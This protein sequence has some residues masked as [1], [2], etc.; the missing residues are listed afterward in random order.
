MNYNVA[1]A[2]TR[3]IAVFL[4]ILLV[5]AV[6]VFG[7]AP[8]N[9]SGVLN[10]GGIKLGLDLAGGSLIVY[11]ADTDMTG[12]DLQMNMDAV[13]TLM[14]S[15]LDNL[16]FT[17]AV[18]TV[19]NKQI[20]I[21]I[22]SVTDPEEAIKKIGATAILQFRNA[23]GEVIIDGK[24]IKAAYAQY[25]AVDNDNVKEYFVAIELTDEGQQ[26]FKE[27]TRAAIGSYISIYL[28]EDLQST[29]SVNKEIDGNPIITNSA[30]TVD[31]VKWLASVINAGQLPFALENVQQD[32]VGATLGEKSLESCLIA[33][34][35]GILLVMAFMII[36]YKVP[37]VVAS[38]SLFAYT[39]LF[40]MVMELIQANLT[41]P[42]IAGIILSIGMAVD[43]NV[44][45]YERI[46]E[47]LRN[48]K[49]VKGAIEAGFNRAFTAIFDSNITTLI[50]AGVLWYFGSGSIKGFGTTLFIGVL[51]SMLTA[52]TLTKSLLRTTVNM[53][54]TKLSYYGLNEEK[55]VKKSLFEKFDVVKQRKFTLIIVACVIIIGTASM[56]LRGFNLD[57]DFSGGTEFILGIQKDVE[58]ADIDNIKSIVIGI[59]EDENK[60]VS[61]QKSAN[62]DTTVI[63]TTKELNEDQR[64]AVRTTI[65]D[66]YNID[67]DND[68]S[69][70]S[71]GKSI[72][73]KLRQT[74]I[75]TAAL[76]VL[77]VLVYISFRFAF[78]SGIAAI[79]CLVH[80]LFIVI[81]AYSLLQ[82]PVSSTIIAA[83][84]TILGYSINATI[85]IFDRIREESKKS[86]SDSF[87]TNVNKGASASMTRSINTTITTFLT[88]G[89]VF[90]FG[91]ESVRNFALP[92]M[93]GLI[94]GLFSSVMIS[95]PM[96]NLLK[97][98][99]GNI[100]IRNLIPK[101]LKK[102]A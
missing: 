51:L 77:L 91:V 4:C 66:K 3:F 11:E 7:F 35:I 59:A 95:G 84:L 21:E 42:G 2:I 41:L 69:V 67:D 36:I 72:S 17:E 81:A 27:G 57:I 49:S 20:S 12:D 62:D 8:L 60:L 9:I 80:D 23:D 90:L 97:S 44:V 38:I 54:I 46:K 5:G 55:M 24:H 65:A 93:I 74:A 43:A 28:D 86:N 78:L 50:A 19:D 30:F 39:A 71:I 83:L 99:F 37:G 85:I 26:K 29:A 102:K 16:G 1:G 61:I 98:K 64:Q 73:D 58:D 33:G 10:S 31:E 15:R 53:Q 79:L 70:R 96:W 88:I 32:S 100:S 34:I 89:M 52:L 82:I 18:L 13:E 25:G 48:G 92:I 45:I 101:K 22:P 76:A 75:L 68:L 40:V 56:V 94:A 14:R 63:I 6:A 47:E 87:A